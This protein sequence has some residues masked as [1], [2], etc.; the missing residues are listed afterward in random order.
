[1]KEEE[2]KKKNQTANPREERK[3]KS[4]KVVK[5]CDWVLF[6]GP[7]CLFNYNIVIELSVFITHNSKIRKLS[8]GNR[9]MD[10]PNN[11]F[12][13]GPTIFKL[14]VMEIENWVMETSHPN[15]P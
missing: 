6:V 12:A 2:E 9:V 8:G 4:Q 1:M 7:L 14:W 15:N 5:R 3:K 11:L 13:M 10:F